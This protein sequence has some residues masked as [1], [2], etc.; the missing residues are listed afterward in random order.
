MC[1][2]KSLNQAANNA[3]Q[4]KIDKD[5]STEL[6][7]MQNKDQEII[8]LKKSLD[9][10]IQITSKINEFLWSVI[11][12]DG[13][14]D[15]FYTLSLEKITGYTPEELKK[16]PGRGLNLVFGEDAALVKDKL[17]QFEKDPN[18]LSI[19]LIYRIV[20]KSGEPVWLKESIV[21]ERDKFGKITRYDGIVSDISEI[22][23][24]EDALK[25]SEDSLVQSNKSKDRFISIISHDLRA[26]FTSILGFAEILLNESDL[27][28]ND[29]REYLNYIYESS[30]NQLQLV[31]YLLDYSRLQ[32]GRTK[33][34]LQRI[35]AK[36]LVY[37]CVSALT[38]NAMRKDITIKTFAPADIHIQADERLITQALTNL[39]SNAIKFTE[40]GKSIEVS[41]N[42][43]KK[44]W[45][46]FVVKDEGLGISEANKPK[47]FQFDQKISTEGTKG[48]KGTGLGL[49]LVKEI[50]EKHNGDIWFYSELGNGSEFHFTISEA[51]NTIILVED[52]NA[53]MILWK[54]LINRNLPN[55]EVITAS[56][57]YEAIGIIQKQIPTIVVTDH[58]MPLMNGIQLIT[59][60]R[61]K[62][63]NFRIP[64]IVISGVEIEEIKEKY[65]K[66]GVET[67]LSK[68]V[69]LKQFQE[70]LLKLAN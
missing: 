59:S 6:T 7:P 21:V 40:E 20:K 61:K 68:P 8:E 49:T 27:S 38:G 55:F 42:V 11:Y 16:M 28:A 60:L 23:K 2:N 25:K 63:E 15:V 19:D 41:V 9:R 39:L 34:E 44:G 62:D 56:N 14:E 26:P 5:D 66:L 58:Q 10:F 22:K 54:K 32:T 24:I 53:S 50:I 64:V 37:S 3:D 30:Q 33:L 43:F 1:E 67:I 17:S 65:L 52:E 47:I 57:G 45:I 36:T 31:N 4:N 46:E 48:E 12:V 51:T 13:I 18:Q 70:I 35:K 69:D 29:K